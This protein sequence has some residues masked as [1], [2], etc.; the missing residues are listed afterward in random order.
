MIPSWWIPEKAY[1]DFVLIL[2]F[3]NK[4][5]VELLQSFCNSAWLNIQNEFVYHPQ[6][7]IQTWLGQSR[8][9]VLVL[10]FY[11]R[12]LGSHTA[13]GSENAWLPC[14]IITYP[15]FKLE[16]HLNQQVRRPQCSGNIRSTGKSVG[17]DLNALLEK[18][19]ETTNNP[20]NYHHLL[21]FPLL[22]K[23]HAIHL[24][25]SPAETL[26]QN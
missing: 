2:L 22:A 25:K 13:K 11:I 12:H 10:F 16:G 17:T 9:H 7:L 18:E 24:Q 5:S 3:W 4:N 19:K 14:Q 21:L 20:Y 1:R 23:K 26:H 15:L 6:A 8:L